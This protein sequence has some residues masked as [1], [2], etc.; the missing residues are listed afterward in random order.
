MLVLIIGWLLIINQTFLALA[1]SVG[2]LRLV[3]ERKANASYEGRIEVY[4]D[5]SWV[6]INDKQ[7]SKNDAMVACRQLGYETGKIVPIATRGGYYGVGNGSIGI[8]DLDCTGN[9]TLLLSCPYTVDQGYTY[10]HYADGGLRCVPKSFNQSTCETGDVRL[11]NESTSNLGRVDVCI[12]NEWGTISRTNF[13]HTEARVICRQLGYYDEFAQN[14]DRGF[15]L[16]LN[17]SPVLLSRVSCIGT[18]SRILD[19]NY[20]GPSSAD[21]HNKDTGAFC[22]DKPPSPE[23]CQFGK[24]RLVNGTKEGEGRVELCIAGLWGTITDDS[25]GTN[26]AKVVCRQLGYS[27]E[28]P[29]VYKNAHFGKGSGY[30]YLDNLKCSGTEEKVLNCGYVTTVGADTHDEDVGVKCQVTNV[31]SMMDITSSTLTVA[32]TKVLMTTNAMTIVRPMPTIRSTEQVDSN[33]DLIRNWLIAAG[34][35]V[36]ALVA[37][38]TLTIIAAHYIVKKRRIYSG[39]AQFSSRDFDENQVILQ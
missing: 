20:N 7:W 26:D 31:T 34:A 28:N 35:T 21:R 29:I 24:I 14:R 33:D 9:E 17:T 19:C 1:E 13:D 3:H 15:E 38:T 10:K 36:I 2:D 18:E 32:S 11:V 30:I 27:T 39:I 12:G 37:L 5:N 8:T 16:G 22:F 4:Y 25:F 23:N 6:A